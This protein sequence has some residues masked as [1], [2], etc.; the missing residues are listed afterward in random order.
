MGGGGVLQIITDD[1]AG[2]EGEGGHSMVTDDHSF[3]GG[4]E[5]FAF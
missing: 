2:W 3:A 4:A 1:H 5:V